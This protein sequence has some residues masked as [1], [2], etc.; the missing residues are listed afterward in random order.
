MWAA[1]GSKRG[2]ASSGGSSAGKFSFFVASYAAMQ[3]LSGSASG[4]GGDLRFGK[5]DGLSGADEI[6]RQIA[7]F[8]SYAGASSKV[9]GAR[10]WQR[11]QRRQQGSTGQRHRSRW[12]WALGCDRLGASDRR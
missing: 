11:H 9:A 1:A 8:I 12:R 5:A 6:C 7:E 3:R 2:A 4:F 10:F